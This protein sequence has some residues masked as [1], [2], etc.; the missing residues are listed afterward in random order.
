MHDYIGLAHATDA[1][2]AWD[3]GDA[4][5]TL[6]AGRQALDYWQKHAP[7]YPLMWTALFPLLAA[8]VEAG[9]EAGARDAAARL[10]DPVQTALPKPLEEA[11]EIAA[12]GGPESADSAPWS[13]ILDLARA[14]GFL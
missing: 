14:Q 7:H 8:C 1:W 6:E 13:R 3:A 2:L 4:S 9:D 11:L 12:A 5:A 10:L